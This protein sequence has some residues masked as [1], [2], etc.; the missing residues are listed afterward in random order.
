M[1]N[2]LGVILYDEDA[3]RLLKRLGLGGMIG[4]SKTIDTTV[5]VRVMGAAGRTKVGLE[6]DL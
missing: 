1:S 6:F 5:R 4:E 2:T 3:K